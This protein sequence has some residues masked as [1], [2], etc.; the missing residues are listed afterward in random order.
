MAQYKYSSN[1]F[2]ALKEEERRHG[3]SSGLKRRGGVTGAI[4]EQVGHTQKRFF[5]E[6]F[7][8]LLKKRRE[9][10]SLPSNTVFLWKSYLVVL[11]KGTPSL[12]YSE[13]R[14]SKLVMKFVLPNYSTEFSSF[15]RRLVFWQNV[16]LG[17]FLFVLDGTQC[18]TYTRQVLYE[19]ATASNSQRVESTLWGV[20]PL[21]LH[22]F[23]SS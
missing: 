23:C 10:I 22:N 2:R 4:F 13:K 17:L 20:L 3:R 5:H 12:G 7:S 8:V 15:F 16:D 9:G 18:L 19:E 11:C 1:Y 14:Q 6:N 21:H